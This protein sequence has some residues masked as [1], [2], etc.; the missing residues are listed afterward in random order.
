MFFLLS[1]SM[2]NLACLALCL[3]STPNYRYMLSVVYSTQ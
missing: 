3:A 1:Y 2:V